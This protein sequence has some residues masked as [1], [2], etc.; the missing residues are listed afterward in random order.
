[1]PRTKEQNAEYCRRYYLANKEKMNQRSKETYLARKKSI[2]DSKRLWE[3]VQ[4]RAKKYDLA[5]DITEED[6]VI[7]THCPVFP[8]IELSRD[9]R[10]DNSPSVDKINP[11]LGYTKG[12]VRVISLRANRLKSD[13]TRRELEALL[14]DAN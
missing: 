5:F 10:Y 8:W 3:S 2:S 11:A 4:M 7:P 14:A 1:M 12:N 6:I 13:S 9:G